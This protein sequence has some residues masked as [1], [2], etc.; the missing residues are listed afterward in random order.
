VRAHCRGAVQAE[1]ALHDAD[2]DD[3][4]DRTALAAT[5]LYITVFNGGDDNAGTIDTSD[6]VWHNGHQAGEF[7][8]ELS[9]HATRLTRCSMAVQHLR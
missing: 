9:I 1:Q 3:A 5:Q 2:L 7:V 8:T 4:E 6:P